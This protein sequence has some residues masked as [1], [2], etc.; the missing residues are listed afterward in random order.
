MKIL[1]F[2]R[3][4]IINIFIFLVMFFT[5]FWI[6]NAA[7]IYSTSEG[8]SWSNPNT[9]EWWVVPWYRDDVF[10]KSDSIYVDQDISLFN[11][12]L[13]W[14]TLIT[15]TSI[16]FYTINLYG[17]WWKILSNNNWLIKKFEIWVVRSSFETDINEL[18]ILW[19][20]HWWTIIWKNI[21]IAWNLSWSIIA[22]NIIVDERLTL[23]W[24]ITSLWYFNISWKFIVNENWVV[25]KDGF[26]NVYNFTINWDVLNKWIIWW[27]P[28]RVDNT[29]FN[30]KVKWNLFN[31]WT[32]SDFEN[33]FL[34]WHIENNWVI[35]DLKT[36][37]AW[38]KIWDY[39]QY[40]FKFWSNPTSSLS[41]TSYRVSFDNP[42]L[43]NNTWIVQWK[44]STTTSSWNESRCFNV[45]WCFE[46]KDYVKEEVIIPTPQKLQQY[47]HSPLLEEEIL[48]LWTKVWKY[49]SWS[50]II[51][52]AEI[53]NSTDEKYNMVFDVY[54]HWMD[55]SIYSKSIQ[56]T[57]WTWRV[58]L[59]F[60]WEW[61]YVWTVKVTDNFWNQS[62][63]L[64]YWTD[65]PYEID[66]SFFKWFE[67]YPYGYSFHNWSP[68]AWLLNW[69]YEYLY[70]WDDVNSNYIAKIHDWN[71]WDLFYKT[72]DTSKL[73]WD[74]RKLVS[75]F[76]SSWLEN[77]KVFQW[78]NC[79]WLAYSS[80]LSAWNKD[81]LE[82]EYP[83]F[84]NKIVNSNIFNW[85]DAPSSLWNSSWD[86]YD[87]RL[88][89]ILSLYLSQL[90]SN[91]QR[92][93]LD[94]EIS[95]EDLL[96]ELSKIE[97]KN[98]LY[99]LN[100]YWENI[101]WEVVAHTVFPYRVDWNKVY[102]VDNN[103]AYPDR[104]IRTENFNA[105][106]QY[107]EI[108]DVNSKWSSELYTL[109]WWVKFTD[110]SLMNLDDLYN[111]WFKSE[112]FGYWV[113]D[114]LYTLSWTW[115]I[116]L[117]DEAWRVTWYKD[118]I[119]YK[120]I[121]WVEII[122]LLSANIWNNNTNDFK[123]IYIPEYIDNVLIE[124]SWTN[125]WEYDLMISSWDFFTEFKDI[126][127]WS[128]EVDKYQ[129]SR[130]KIEFDFDDN[131][132]WTYNLISHD[133]DNNGTGTIYLWN[134]TIEEWLTKLDI[135]WEEV[136]NNWES[137]IIKSVDS[138]LDWEFEKT[139]WIKPITKNDWKKWEISWVVFKDKNTN[140][141]LDDSDKLLKW[142]KVA[143]YEEGWDGFL[144]NKKWK[145]KKN[146]KH[147]YKCY[148]WLKNPDKHSNKKESY[149]HEDINCFVKTNKKW[150]YSFKNLEDWNYMIELLN[151]K[152]KKN[153]DWFW[154]VYEINILNGSI[155]TDNNF[156]ISKKWKK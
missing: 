39:T 19:W 49:Q 149:E 56:V 47:I 54:K 99:L 120:E 60:L 7:T 44:D 4:K 78:W 66:F 3:K 155:S 43:N 121:P 81:L 105:Y 5:Y 29:F 117:T 45:P 138:D 106:N 128:W 114:F 16:H 94:S 28:D 24:L 147:K 11:L 82:K 6:S 119:T 23:W 141:E 88:E 15:D 76:K 85:I 71:L 148:S 46:I 62:D 83:E 96:S 18:Y 37:L 152:N 111:W 50:W 72:F 100:L 2:Y 74:N 77:W 86:I 40:N 118:N 35:D 145:K 98:N 73:E 13:L 67:P 21:F 122:N 116:L 146:T 68:S 91:T 80:I 41:T 36:Y 92:V 48:E 154:E 125:K 65:L 52:E 12:H 25:K 123:Q 134:T 26:W 97:N 126:S 64:N 1:L 136:I 75:A 30:M 14:H 69:W 101:N 27:E 104:D 129:I 20:H 55:T 70:L 150:E 156:W 8:G 9:W 59:P 61:D 84:Y 10:I 153:K 32:I 133:F 140:W 58:V 95:P 87:Y 115:E 131:K 109:D 22:N 108:D 127:T 144:Y 63:I 124:V 103:I 135:N 139:E 51:L 142:Y 79:Y 89:T 93:I 151:N 34:F 33:L 107:I 57:T 112:P 130:E 143:L 42:F 53:E 38:D 113:N 102:I 17:N 137:S 31:S 132:E 90:S 110:L